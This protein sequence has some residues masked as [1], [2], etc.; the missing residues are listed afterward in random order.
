MPRPMLSPDSTALPLG[1]YLS[2]PGDA[3]YPALC[4]RIK[5]RYQ[6]VH[7]ARLTY[8]H[9]HQFVL[10]QGGQW[11]G[12]AGFSSARTAPLYLEQY[13]DD[14][15]EALVSDHLGRPVARDGI[16]EVGNLV[17]A[18]G[19]S[20]PLIAVLTRFFSSV[21]ADVVVFTGTPLLLA[22]FYR[23][24]IALIS[25]GAALPERLSDMTTQWGRYYA[26]RPVV[27]AAPVAASLASLDR[28]GSQALWR[29]CPLPRT[30]LQEI[31][32]GR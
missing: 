30:T 24:R 12:S 3:D 4:T 26:H 21:N 15:I 23:L 10:D 1:S 19:Y 29:S 9:P 5:T 25:L 7:D 31:I 13:L 8:F 6:Q 32:N 18:S 17:A 14:P 27:V 20:R 16:I 28:G 22:A 11:R 2:G